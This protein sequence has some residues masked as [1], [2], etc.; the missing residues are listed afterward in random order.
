MESPDLPSKNCNTTSLRPGFMHCQQRQL[1]QTDTSA[2]ERLYL[3]VADVLYWYVSLY[4][5]VHLWSCMLAYTWPHM[6]YLADVSPVEDSR[7]YLSS[8]GADGQRCHLHQQC[9]YKW[10]TWLTQSPWAVTHEFCSLAYPPAVLCS[11]P[12]SGRLTL[13]CLWLSSAESEVYLKPSLLFL[14]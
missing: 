4:S 3:M 6:C 9:T 7:G 8:E 10:Q 1:L 5:A 12:A 11:I 2:L 13:P 14:G